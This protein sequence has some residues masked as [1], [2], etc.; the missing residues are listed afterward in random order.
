MHLME[1]VLADIVWSRCLVY[2]DDI[3]AFRVTFHAALLNLQCV[4]NRLRGTNLKLKVKK[5]ELVHD[6]LE[7]L[8]HEVS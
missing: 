2:L 5:C 8:G 3:V 4:F 1:Q 7:Y 6:K